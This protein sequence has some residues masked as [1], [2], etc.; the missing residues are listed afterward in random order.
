MP[1]LTPKLVAILLVLRRYFFMQTAQIR[2]AVAPAD[3]DGSV[4]REQLQ[5]LLALHYVRR[6]QPRILELGKATAPPVFLPTV[7]GSCALARETGDIGHILQVEPTFK[8]WL[9]IHHYCALTALHMTIDAAI[10]A[11]SAVKQHALYFEHEVIQPDALEPSTRFR[12]NTIVSDTPRVVCCPDSA[13]EIEVSGHRRAIYVEREMGSDTPMRVVAKK[14]KGMALLS[15]TGLFRRHFPHAKDMRVLA[16]AP[17]PSWRDGLRAAFREKDG[18]STKLKPGAQ[19][20]LFI[21]VQD[22][23][24]EKILHEP[25]VHT[26]QEKDGV[27]IERGPLPLVPR[28]AGAPVTGATTGATAGATAGGHV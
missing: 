17:N 23:T 20:W 18:T 1:P 2:Q 26:I 4:T 7:L 6:H 27:V 15:D 10:N 24:V 13:F 22:L 11:Q 12:L 8:D 19:L 25:T 21:A 16:L 14:H 9:S 3:K 28:P 5:K